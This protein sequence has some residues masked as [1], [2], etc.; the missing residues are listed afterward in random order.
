[1]MDWVVK[2]EGKFERRREKKRRHFSEEKIKRMKI[3]ITFEVRRSKEIN[4]KRGEDY[5]KEK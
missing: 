1:M 5:E 4:Y 2:K 3:K